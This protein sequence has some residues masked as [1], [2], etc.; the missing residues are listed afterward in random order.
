MKPFYKL[1][2][3]LDREGPGNPADVTWA[4]DVVG[5]AKDA[6]ICD[7]GCGSGADIGPLLAAAPD[8]HVTAIDKQAHFID[9][10]RQRVG[11]D[12]RVTLQTGDMADIGGPYDFIWCA[13]AAYFLGVTQA[14]K[15]WRKSLAPGGVIAFSEPCWWQDPTSAEARALWDDY[16]AMTAE[17]GIQARIDAAGYETLATRRID[18]DGWNVYYASLEARIDLLRP[19]ADAALTEVLDASTTEIATW[20]ACPGEYGYLLSVVRPK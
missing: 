3:G 6:R 17:E 20:R 18:E 14:L 15:L 16:A 5:L 9:E 2:Q 8:G 13:G 1:Y 7:V 11:S 4:T 19:E 12:S 10:A